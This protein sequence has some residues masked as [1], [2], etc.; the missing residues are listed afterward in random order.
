MNVYDD[1]RAYFVLLRSE[2]RDVNGMLH[3]ISA[4]VE[5]LGEPAVDDARMREL[6]ESLNLLRVELG[7]HFSLEECEGCLDEAVSRCP[8]LGRE[9]DAII[10]EQPRLLD[11][12]DSLI[13]LASRLCDGD[14]EQ[15]N[16]VDQWRRF[17][18]ALNDHEAAE[19]RVLRQGLE[20]VATGL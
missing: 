2:H 8:S 6:I 15:S 19:N 20:S 17:A 3:H 1:K 7:H 5:Q 12:L 13:A 16:F 9:V 11:Q 14:A 10:A 4:A 18:N